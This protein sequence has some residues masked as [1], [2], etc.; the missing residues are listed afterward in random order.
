MTQV[1]EVGKY[2]QIPH[3]RA[4]TAFWMASPHWWPVI[5]PQHEAAEYI[6]FPHQH[7]HIDAR[8]LV[9][10]KA[11]AA[12]RWG[13]DGDDVFATP[14]NRV[15]PT[16]WNPRLFQGINES[17]V[18]LDLDDMPEGIEEDR[19][20]RVM[21]TLC[22]RE[23]PAHVLHEPNQTTAKHG[24]Q[25]WLPELE[26]AYENERLLPGR[27]CPHRGGDLSTFRPDPEGCV[28][29]PLHG[30]KWHVE[31]GTLRRVTSTDLARRAAPPEHPVA[32]WRFGRVA[33]RLLRPVGLARAHQPGR[34]Q[35]G[36]QYPDGHGRGGDCTRVD[37]V[38]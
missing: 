18:G 3:V 38:P 33:K 37:R 28:T 20:L 9:A 36:D 27:I 4:K 8:F 17:H 22:K 34:V 15:W 23:Y 19:Y 10:E 1:Y 6:R 16:G 5:G 30:L 25:G 24:F 31:T 35:S 26:D 7:Y 12:N 11:R 21:R 13:S 32:G 2:Y 14:I 29:C